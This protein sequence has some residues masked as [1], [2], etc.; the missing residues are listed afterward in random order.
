[1]RGGPRAHPRLVPCGEGKVTCRSRGNGE[2]AARPR[3]RLITWSVA[4]FRRRDRRHVP[5]PGPRVGRASGLYAPRRGADWGVCRAQWG[6]EAAG[7]PGVWDWQT[8]GRQ[9]GAEPA[10]RGP[11]WGRRLVR[12]GRRSRARMPPPRS[13][14]AAVAACTAGDALAPAAWGRVLRCRHATQRPGPRR[15]TTPRGCPADA[16]HDPGGLRHSGARGG[17]CRGHAARLHAIAKTGGTR[18]AGRPTQR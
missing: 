16:R 9:R 5:A 18:C 14:A 4:E 1:M 10:E 8:G 15:P 3:G 11:V 2:G 6:Q 13:K 7:T 12:R 17:C